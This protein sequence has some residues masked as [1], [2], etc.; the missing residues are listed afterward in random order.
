MCI[1]DRASTARVVIEEMQKAP[2]AGRR[3]VLPLLSELATPAT[4]GHSPRLP[5]GRDHPG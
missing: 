4:L 2:A 1:R 5:D 3:R